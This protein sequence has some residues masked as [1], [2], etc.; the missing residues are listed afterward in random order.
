MWN[1]CVVLFAAWM[2]GPFQTAATIEP[3]DE[4]SQRPDFAAFRDSLQEA[5]SRRDSKALLDIVDPSIKNSFGGN[6]GIEEFKDMWHP[7]RPDSEVWKEL[8]AVLSLGGTFTAPNQFTAPYTFSK[9]PN[10]VDSYDNIAVTGSNVR[11]RSAPS[12]DASILTRVS[13]AIL[14][15]AEESRDGHRAE[16]TAVEVNGRTGYIKSEF[17]RSPIDYRAAFEF[18]GG[19][20]RLVFFLNGD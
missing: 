8:G 14:K 10:D 7:E 4:A 20:W 13:F 5:V 15:L 18:S 3:V 6:G 12:L 11:I 19:Q 2:A 17:V 16:W 9:W 1:A